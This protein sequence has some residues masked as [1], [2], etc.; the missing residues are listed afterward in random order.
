MSQNRAELILALRDEISSGMAKI[1]A[2]LAQTR[3]AVEGLGGAGQQSFAV[4]ASA[5]EAYAGSLAKQIGVYA[6]VAAAAYKTKQ[7]VVDTFKAGVQAVD[8]YQVRVIGIA[9]TWTDMAKSGQGSMGEM[10]ARNKAAAEDM[11]KGITVESAKHFSSAREGFM[12]LNRLAQSG[13]VVRQQEIGALLTLT[14]K[15]K[16][17]TQGQNVEMQLNTEIIALMQGQAKA[18]SMLAMELQSRLGPG[19]KDLVAKHRAA[20]DLLT[21]ITGLYPGLTAANREIENTM[22]AQ[23][24]TTKG[25]LEL[26]A[27]GGLSGA[28]QDI[29]G[30][31]KEINEY[32]RDHRDELV[33]K[34]ADTWKGVSGSVSS[35]A[36]FIVKATVALADFGA[37][38]DK[39][40]QN[41]LI[42]ILWGAA[43]GSRF[44]PW[45]AVVGAGIGGGAS[46]Q[47]GNYAEVERGLARQRASQGIGPS[48]EAAETYYG[49][50]SGGATSVKPPATDTDKGGGKGG[51]A[52]KA[53]EAAERSLENFVQRMKS[54]TARAS[55]EGMAALGEWYAKSS[56]ELD[57]ITG[58]VG[59]SLAARQALDDAYN[60]KRTKIE[61]DFYTLVA[62][63]SGNAYA[64][65]EAQATNWLT[66]YQGIAGAE[67]EIAAIKARKIWELDVKN[68]ID[69]LGL[70]K[71]F[72]DQAAGLAVDLT[73][74]IGLRR[75]A[76]NREIEI[77]RYQLAVQL[78]Q[79]TVA[80]KI[81][82]EER[83]RYL[84]NQVLLDQQKRFN[85]EME[86]NKGLTGWAWSR[87]KEADQRSTVKDMM[88][89]LESGFQSAFSSGLQGVL[90]RDKAT[91]KNISKTLW[92][93]GIGEI[94]KG[95]ITRMVDAGAKLL[96]PQAPS[97]PAAGA[98]AGSN[99]A[100]QMG[101]AAEGLKEAS[102][103]FNINTAQFGLAAGGLLLSGI[104]I[105]TNSQFL[106][107]AGTALQVAGLAIQLYEALATTAEL[108]AS[109]VLS[110]A[111]MTLGVA[112]GSLIAAAYALMAA[113]AVDAIPFLHSGGMILHGGGPILPVV[114]AHA[115]LNL[116]DDERLI[117]GQ[118]GEGMLSRRGMAG[119]SQGWF[120]DLN[121]G[122][123]DLLGPG[124]IRRR[125]GATAPA[126]ANAPGPSASAPAPRPHLNLLIQL[127]S[128]EILREDDIW[129]MTQKGLNK[130][131][132]RIQTR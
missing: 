92:T 3:Q 38:L 43:A 62:K 37:K 111:G 39:I 107:Y 23:H 72:Y 73:A 109:T 82:G 1:N 95:S 9:A 65:I 42:G 122:N 94:N 123:Y 13:Y 26:L 93:S 71:S 11:Y 80:K 76:L 15:I 21:W 16:L 124:L 46:A 53:L 20:G 96:R 117:I 103:G 10:F 97:G 87:A 22:N 110:A 100:A 35:I 7:A 55:G 49:P 63:E 45:G 19:W 130:G 8:E 4:Q 88:G 61:T 51:D 118:T 89:G 75:E 99:Y 79:L 116:K 128:G 78:E 69:R 41:P 126:A 56:L 90:T 85:F 70:E 125:G 81:T 12:V 115:G 54:E 14:D 5:S 101:Q 50:I 108:G 98:Q 33:S 32:L 104:G 66:K 59:E 17:A 119:L 86:H 77:Q 102:A 2:S 36:G 48:G 121:Q 68:Y 112:G 105:A 113:A 18:Q 6:L 129:R 83:D 31:Q 30:W 25:L 132:I 29:V 64:G 40:A 127:P 60:S 58:K 120:D 28:Y 84:A 106:V 27:I 47:A 52:D 131:K 114:Y 74:Q 67:T 24:A 44:G 57:R 91:L 34:I